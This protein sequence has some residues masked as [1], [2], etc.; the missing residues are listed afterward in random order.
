MSAPIFF[1]RGRGLTVREIATLAGAEPRRGADLDRQITGVAAL[2]HATPHDLAFLDNVRY[3]H[4][5]ATTA[6]AACLT[7]ERLAARIPAHVNLLCAHKPYQGFVEVARA[8]FPDSLRPSSLFEAAGVASGAVV[9]PTARL[10]SGVAIDPGAVVGPRAEI[11][12]GTVIGVG[13][14]IGPNVRIGRGCAIGPHVSII[15]ALVGDRVIIHGG[16]RIGQDGFGYLMGAKG[17]R[18]VPQIGRVIIQ[19]EVEI[20]A[21]TTIDRG[22][23][24]DTVIG[25]GTKI[26]NLVQVGHNVTIG[27]HCIL[28]AQTGISGSVTLEDY[29]VLGARV[30]VNNHVTIGEGAQIA[31]TSIV[32]DNVP[33]GA[34]WGGTPAKPAKLWFREMAALQRLAREPAGSRATRGADE[35][36]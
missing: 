3:A 30:G 7:L 6:A 33:P 25:E 14:A 23:S 35:E 20:G 5:A 26:D 15:H 19:D 1:K 34:R 2:D 27:R 29:V 32:K 31:A 17:H 24:R 9:H 16:C 11:G 28:V 13:S 10:E 21:G 36:Q 8:L 22:A 4:Q 18:K 12:S